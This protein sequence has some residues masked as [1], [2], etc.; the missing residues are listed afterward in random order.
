MI[1]LVNRTAGNNVNVTEIIRNNPDYVMQAVNQWYD[2]I[3]ET[4]RTR[5]LIGDLCAGGLDK[6]YSPKQI[7]DEIRSAL[8]YGM[9]PDQRVRSVNNLSDASKDLLT[10]II[11]DSKTRQKR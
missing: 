11:I 9:T 5:P 7:L 4:E 3:P 10:E 8:K 2:S 6:T 1:E